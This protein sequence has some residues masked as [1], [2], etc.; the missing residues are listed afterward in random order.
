MTTWRTGRQAVAAALHRG[1][2]PVPEFVDS[3]PDLPWERVPGTSVFLFKEAGA[4]PPALLENLRHNK[5]LHETVVLLSVATADQPTVPAARRSEVTRVGPGLWQVVL[6][7]GFM[8]NPDVP[9][10]LTEL[11]ETSEAKGLHF[12]VSD[13]TY[14][15][16]RETIV[17]APLRTM[18]PARE[19]LFIMQ[20]RTAA[21]AAR[22][23]RLP[24]ARVF[25]VGTTIEI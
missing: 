21:S 24:A 22:F 23:F 8:D 9:A 12:D 20:N 7:F 16:G 11:S 19:Q 1:E 13:V 2:T 25:E 3:L 6:T 15:L 14:F 4:T 18:N 10:A 17:A 5:V